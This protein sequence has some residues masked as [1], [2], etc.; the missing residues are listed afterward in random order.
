MLHSRLLLY[1]I[2]CDSKKNHALFSEVKKKGQLTGGMD[3]VPQRGEKGGMFRVT[4]VMH[5]TGG[6][7][8]LTDKT[9]L[10]WS[11][12]PMLL[13]EALV[14]LFHTPTPHFTTPS[15]SSLLQLS[16]RCALPCRAS[17]KAEPHARSAQRRRHTVQITT[18]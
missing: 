9:G 1:F 12:N 11:S 18:S 4:P 17:S 10:L 15:A 16:G 2:L 5:F 3:G 14:P 13:F 6:R 8:G 7:H